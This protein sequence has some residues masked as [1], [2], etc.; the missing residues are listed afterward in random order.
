[1][2]YG[3][4]V[5][6]DIL[7]KKFLNDE[8]NK[9]SINVD[10]NEIK[11]I[12]N[13]KNINNSDLKKI[14]DFLR[15]DNLTI[16]LLDMINEIL[17]K[18]ENNI[19]EQDV[20]SIL[21]FLNK[22]IDFTNK[23]IN[24]I[25]EKNIIHR[26]D[27]INIYNVLK[28]DKF[29]IHI[30]ILNI[31]NELLKK[32]G[33]VINKTDS[34]KILNLLKKDNNLTTKYL[35]M[36][37]K[38]SI[39]KEELK[40]IYDYLIKNNLAVK[41]L[42]MMSEILN[43]M[44]KYLY[45]VDYKKFIKYNFNVDKF[46][47]INY[48]NYVIDTIGDINNNAP[49]KYFKIMQE[50]KIVNYETLENIIEDGDKSIFNVSA[51][52]KTKF[53][54]I[55]RDTIKHF[56]E[57]KDQ[58]INYNNIIK[59]AKVADGL[60][61]DYLFKNL[62]FMTENELFINKSYGNII[63]QIIYIGRIKELMEFINIL[64]NLEIKK[65]IDFESA[66]N[67]IDYFINN[68][69]YKNIYDKLIEYI[70]TN[71]K[72]IN[73][74]IIDTIF[75][76]NIKDK[77]GNILLDGINFIFTWTD[78][79]ID[80][81]LITVYNSS[82]VNDYIN[83]FNSSKK[84]NDKLPFIT[85]FIKIINL[86]N[87]NKDI[88][89]STIAVHLIF[90]LL[91]IYMFNFGQNEI[92][93]LLFYYIIKLLLEGSFYNINKKYVFDNLFDKNYLI[94]ISDPIYDVLN[95][96]SQCTVSY[97][98]DNNNIRQG[99]CGETVLLNIL[100]KILYDNNV[101]NVNKMNKLIMVDSDF[102]HNIKKFFLN[103][104]TFADL[105]NLD[106]CINFT[107]LVSNIPE[108]EY[109]QSI[110]NYRYDLEPTLEN[111]TKLLL[112]ILDGILINTATTTRE[113]YIKYYKSLFENVNYQTKDNIIN[114][115]LDSTKCTFSKRHAF[116]GSE[117][118]EEPIYSISSTP[119][120]YLT[121]YIKKYYEI[122]Y[123]RYIYPSLAT[124]FDLVELFDNLNLNFLD[125]EKLFANKVDVYKEYIPSLI[126]RYK[127]TYPWLADE[128]WVYFTGFLKNQ[129]IIYTAVYTTFYVFE[130]FGNELF[131]NRN[132]NIYINNVYLF[133]TVL[134]E[135]YNETKYFEYLYLFFQKYDE[136]ISTYTLLLEFVLNKINSYEP[137][138][139]EH[140]LSS[141][142]VIYI[143]KRL[144]R[145]DKSELFKLLNIVDDKNMLK[146]YFGTLENPTYYTINIPK[147]LQ[148]KIINR[149]YDNN[150]L[151]DEMFKKIIN[152]SCFDHDQ[153]INILENDLNIIKFTTPIPIPETCYE[154]K[155][156]GI[157]ILIVPHYT[158]FTGGDIDYYKKYKKY[159]LKYI[160]AL[161]ILK[162]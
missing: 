150:K 139:A 116:I 96:L 123:L 22:D 152:F 65:P 1:M 24:M 114:L 5:D 86:D 69:E 60:N 61:I 140:Y 7:F 94:D 156:F 80:D 127:K 29:K 105:N 49:F 118:N 142:L 46:K 88:I 16:H 13:K 107:K 126:S 26:I 122:V 78:S 28:E 30:Y 141:K 90:I 48:A 109:L 64:T 63:N 137:K 12:L 59:I 11:K 77:S 130:N 32:K 35:N 101:L 110:N 159:K 100:E 147:E 38:N 98:Y 34:E 82:I 155:L 113:D 124:S 146:K 145:L 76:K 10:D 132:Y 75:R 121:L 55:Y 81:R 27:L 70:S 115:F 33:D 119:I 52:N 162:S 128:L 73:K 97:I 153:D 117:S 83:S 57:C 20:K 25:N 108:I 161:N 133:I 62:F 74:N 44:Y 158:S 56:D 131:G 157:D 21:D 85:S 103:H 120:L 37:D 68:K 17:N 54:D 50:G 84:L 89:K 18:R 47:V 134:F 45:F 148:I 15:K 53:S 129:N 23:I 135:K 92:N 41:F 95:K 3:G 87:K 136:E 71:N 160:H 43:S 99:S 111:I 143:L 9:F 58:I 91:P 66:E 79:F 151:P 102:H 149:K 104:K 125:I 19:N 40:K 144:N 67:E 6:N 31:I 8:F 14:R 36:I 154:K 51:K 72:I 39:N 93:K 138:D 106:T 2:T 112:Y 4:Y 42:D